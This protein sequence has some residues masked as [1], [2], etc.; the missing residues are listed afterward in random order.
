MR[1]AITLRPRLINTHLHFDRGSG[2]WR[3]L[4]SRK[5]GNLREKGVIRMSRDKL[6]VRFGSQARW[7]TPRVVMRVANGEV[8]NQNV[9]RGKTEKGCFPI[10]DT[11]L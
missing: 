7:F 9:Q 2:Y 8:S 5:P 10:P 3:L 1:R 11:V 6:F 4:V